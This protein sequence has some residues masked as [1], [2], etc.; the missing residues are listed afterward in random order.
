MKTYVIKNNF[1][2]INWKVKILYETKNLILHRNVKC[3]LNSRA[4]DYTITFKDK[5]DLAV[6]Y[7]FTAKI[8]DLKKLMNRMEF[9]MMVKGNKKEFLSKSEEFKK[10][11][12]SLK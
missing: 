7:Y 11:A 9:F 5:N 1:N 10:L 6:N 2:G 4:R 12:R 8:S 3:D